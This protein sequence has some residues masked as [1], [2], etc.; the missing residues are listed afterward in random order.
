MAEAADLLGD[1]GQLD[2]QGMVVG[3]QLR[4][5][6]LDQRLVA[7][8]E[9]A[10]CPP[11]GAVAEDVERRA[12]QPL[13]PRQHAEGRQQPGAELALF[14]MAGLRVARGDQRRG[15][16]EGEPVAA[17]ELLAEAA[18]RSEEHTSEIQSLMPIS[19]AVF[20]LK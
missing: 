4:Q 3:R 16:V 6:L 12:A 20:C 19:Y 1:R 15:E 18:S 10:L 7:G 9:L 11:L 2:R 13:Q 14:Q 5:H 17:L 8:D